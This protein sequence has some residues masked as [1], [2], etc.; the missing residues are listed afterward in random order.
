MR[1]TSSFRRWLAQRKLHRIVTERRNSFEITD[2]RKR[3]AAALRGHRGKT[4]KG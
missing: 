4:I 3:R 1:L 2:Y